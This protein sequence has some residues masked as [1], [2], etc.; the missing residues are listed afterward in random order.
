MKWT[1]T[2]EIVEQNTT[3]I[4][5]PRTLFIFEV[6]KDNLTGKLWVVFLRLHLTNPEIERL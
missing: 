2:S 5:K 3:D 1:K 6:T 4:E